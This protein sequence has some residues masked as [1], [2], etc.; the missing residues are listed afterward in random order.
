MLFSGSLTAMLSGAVIVLVTI[1]VHELAHGYTAYLLGD[2]TAKNA[3]R[4]SLNPLAH[5]DPLGAIL[6]F[7]TGFGWAKPVP[8]NPFY[9]KGS[10]SRGILLVSLAGP[11]SNVVLA[12]VL[13]MFVPL[14]ARFNMSL[15]QIIASAIYLN[16]YMAIF[17][18]L[19]IPPLDGSKILAS[20][21]PKDTAY[22]FLSVMD[23]YGM[24]L[25]LVLAITNVFGKIISPI[26]GGIYT[27]FVTLAFTLF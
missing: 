14:A 18:L 27:A 20:L 6:L 12:F 26:A 15:A 21:I 10:R 9:F 23:Q 19:P 5:L 25:L 4:L 2:N 13:A 7:V 1:T 8:I 11:L 24:I 16:I 22:K 17:N 3:G